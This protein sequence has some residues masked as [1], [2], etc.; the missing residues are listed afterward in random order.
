MSAEL[1]RIRS[2]EDSR[3]ALLQSAHTLLGSN[4]KRLLIVA[5]FCAARSAPGFGALLDMA[6]TRLPFDDNEVGV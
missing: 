5:W 3:L 1:K 4:F 2:R 6:V